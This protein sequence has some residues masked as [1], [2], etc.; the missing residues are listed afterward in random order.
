[1]NTMKF[2]EAMGKINDKYVS[3]AIKYQKN[4]I[5]FGWKKYGIVAACLALAIISVFTANY[6]LK[7][8]SIPQIKIAVPAESDPVGIRKYMNY[9]GHRYVFIENGSTYSL[10][11]NQLNR[12]LGTLEHDIQSDK[13]NNSGKEFSSTFALGGTVF[14]MTDYDSDYRVAVEWEGN[15]YICQSVGLSDN[16]PMNI[17]EHF[18]AADFPNA[19][20]GISIYDHA[21]TEMLSQIPPEYITTLIST[22]SQAQPAKLTDNDYQ[23]IGKAQKEGKSFQLFLALNDGTIYKLYV[24]PSLEITMIGD[25]R[26]ILPTDF[27]ANFEQLFEGLNQQSLPAM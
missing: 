7:N 11:S 19:V 8:E 12:A 26:Y 18:Q 16:T 9:N 20:N 24:I 10:S 13:E 5:F 14:E 21:G 4:S 15:Y 2:T 22:L 25:N 27:S 6:F 17:S 23:Q 1:M 3:E